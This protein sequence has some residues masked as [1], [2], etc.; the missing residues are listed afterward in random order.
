MY[1]KKNTGHF[2]GKTV[3]LTGF[4]DKNLQEQIEAQGGKISS[5]ISKNTDYLIVNNQ[6]VINEPTEKVQKALKLSIDILT[7]DNAI[8]MLVNCN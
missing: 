4:R 6:Q 5:S 8:K 7:K 3:V 2:T 1:K